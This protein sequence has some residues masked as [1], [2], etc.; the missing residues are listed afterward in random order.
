MAKSYRKFIAGTAAAAV[1]ASAAPGLTVGAAGFN[2]QIPTWAKEAVDYLVGKGAIGGYPDGSYQPYAEIKRGEAAKM[3]AVALGLDIDDNAKASFGDTKDHW[4]SKYV[5]ALQAQKPGVINGYGDGSFKPENT[6]TREELAKMTVEAYGLELD[7]EVEIDF[8]DNTGWGKEYVNVLAS[9]GIVAGVSQ[10]EFDPGANVTRGQF[11]VFVHRAEV[12][13]VRIKVGKP[14]PVAKPTLTI[15]GDSQGN[16]LANGK[17]KTYTVTYKSSDGLPLQGVVLNV[18]F[19]EN[20]ETTKDKQRNVTVTNS[21]NKSVIPYQSTDGEEA[22]AEIRTDKDGKATFTVTGTND[23]VT[24]IVF[25]DGSYQEDDTDGGE[26]Q[27]PNTQND[28]FEKNTELYV[29]APALTFGLTKYKIEIEGKRTKYASI[30]ID[31]N[32]DESITGDE[33]NGRE[34]VIK[35]NK[36]D[37]TPFAGGYVNVA[38]EENVDDVLNNNPKAA[39]F[40][41]FGA[42]Q[43]VV[44]LD[45]KG[46]AKVTLASTAVNDNATPIA[47]IDQNSANNAQSGQLEAGEPVSSSDDFTNFQPSRVDNGQLGA[48]LGVIDLTDTARKAIFGDASWNVEDVKGFQ[49]TF[50]N[51]SGKPFLPPTTADG[52]DDDLT[53]RVNYTI[54]NTGANTIRVHPAPWLV[55]SELENAVGADDT[56]WG[57]DLAGS[58]FVDIYPGGTVTISGDIEDDSWSNPA[59]DADVA[60]VAYSLN[61]ASSADVTAT[62]VVDYEAHE[63]DDRYE[64]SDS[65]AVGPVSTSTTFRNSVNAPRVIKVLEKDLDNDGSI[66]TIELTFDEEVQDFEAPDFRLFTGTTRLDQEVNSV[67]YGKKASNINEDDK[68]KLVLSVEEFD[69][70]GLDSGL[71]ENLTEAV[72]ASLI[73]EDGASA[74][75]I[76][77]ELIANLSKE[78][79]AAIIAKYLTKEEIATAFVTEIDE[80][81]ELN[82]DE[83]TAWLVE[84]LTAEALA[85]ALVYC[86]EAELAQLLVDNLTHAELVEIGSEAISEYIDLQGYVPTTLHYDP[87]FSGSKAITDEFGNRVNAFV[88]KYFDV[89]GDGEKDAD[90]YVVNKR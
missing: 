83:L 61:G 57:S 64:E 5:A 78:E 60:V 82:E 73:L 29:K 44:K 22:A 19:E 2:D 81:A 18:T 67:A 85:G 89:D 28:R 30:A 8:R 36:P 16:E 12:P 53:A 23:T 87:S 39:Y 43:G 7:K 69:G 11:P 50:L 34:Y 71:I 76:A 13:G 3:L 75:E 59:I 42:K 74:Q 25:L 10:G 26:P 72:I 70:L 88:V 56:Q 51:Q 54:T 14:A 35:V 47:W 32:N 66:D 6:I 17:A 20:L 46:E 79:Q 65:V 80:L 21:D 77:N 48:K 4:A 86:S 68:K 58:N 40:V 63:D 84:H 55:D 9:L 31:N 37:G 24:P 49:L 1:V 90:E 33:H 45:S 41:Q 62:G 52:R 15:E 38:I 27:V